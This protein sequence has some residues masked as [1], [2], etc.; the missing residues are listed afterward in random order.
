MA[1][2][3]DFAGSPDCVICPDSALR[4]AV[5]VF[6]DCALKKESW[7]REYVSRNGAEACSSTVQG[8]HFWFV[9][10]CLRGQGSSWQPQNSAISWASDLHHDS[11]SDFQ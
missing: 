1:I 9:T 6:V 7:P 5:H 8:L 3:G 11:K 4:P 10:R 2:V